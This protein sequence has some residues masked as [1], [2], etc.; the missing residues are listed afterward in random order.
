MKVI[1]EWFVEVTLPVDGIGR[2]RLLCDL[3]SIMHKAKVIGQQEFI[4]VEYEGRS[5]A[6]G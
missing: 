3:L 2:Y 4:A 5:C 6:P 1:E